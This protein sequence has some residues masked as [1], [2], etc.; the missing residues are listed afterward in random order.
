[1]KSNKLIYTLGAALAEIERQ[2]QQN[3]SNTEFNNDQKIRLFL[4]ELIVEQINSG[5]PNEDSHSSAH[6][7]R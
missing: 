4:K 5:D 3:N 7:I 2:C 6:A 1:M